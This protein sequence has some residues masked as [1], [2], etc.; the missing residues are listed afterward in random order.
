MSEG[1]RK[2][3]LVVD[4]DADV[5]RLIGKVAALEDADAVLC[6]SAEEAMDL[7]E[8]ERFDLLVTDKN[9]P[10]INGLELARV[11]RAMH[12]GMPVL[13]VTGYSSVE[14][15]RQAA[16]QGIVDYIIKPVIVDELRASLRRALRLAAEVRSHGRSRSASGSETPVDT[17]PASVASPERAEAVALLRSSVPPDR[18][19]PPLSVL[20]VEPDDAHRAALA[21]LFS[22][23]GHQVV[24]FPS[25]ARADGQAIHAG[26]D[27]LVAG[28]EVL[29]TRAHW[30]REVGGRRPLGAMAIMDGLGIDKVIEAIQL[31]AR[32]LV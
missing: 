23:F 21:A 15:A 1:E 8:R 29:K 10:G 30:L 27:L 6:D 16:A 26:F 5:R 20:L 25:A 11:A 9:L 2:R 7:L 24:S 4:D 17:T 22:S 18:K 32:G 13:L 31:G 28:P 12:R 14:S 19:Q 3:V